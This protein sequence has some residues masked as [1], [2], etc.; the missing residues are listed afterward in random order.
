MDNQVS[1]LACLVLVSFG[2]EGHSI[3]QYIVV[4]ADRRVGNWAAEA[5][6]QFSAGRGAG[7]EL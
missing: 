7:A 6:G 4:T 3:L 2:R 1:R 5:L